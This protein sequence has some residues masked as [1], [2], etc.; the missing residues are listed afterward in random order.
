M[1]FSPS[2]LTL[3]L[4]W[5]HPPFFD[6]ISSNRFYRR[7]I[8]KILTATA[9]SLNVRL[10]LDVAPLHAICISL[11]L[12]TYP[13]LDPS[14]YYPRL[15][16]VLSVIFVNLQYD[17]NSFSFILDSRDMALTNTTYLDSFS[18]CVISYDILIFRSLFLI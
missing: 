8:Q 12:R 17:I 18:F 14:E 5:Q 7:T 6:R 13:T 16:Q 11:S 4:C 15:V 1:L 9:L 10:Q 2:I 3:S